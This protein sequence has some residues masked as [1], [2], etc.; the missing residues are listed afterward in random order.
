MYT[1][2]LAESLDV[3]EARRRRPY[4]GAV[5][6]DKTLAIMADT[7]GTAIDADCF[8][9]LKRIIQAHPEFFPK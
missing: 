2:L 3:P 5:P 6:V 9:H 7:V 4:R 8:A 1:A